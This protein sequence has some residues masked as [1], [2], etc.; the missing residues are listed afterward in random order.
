[1]IVVQAS[2]AAAVRSGQERAV[3]HAGGAARSSCRPTRWWGWGRAVG[4]LAGGPLGGLLLAAGS[5]ET[6]VI[7]DAVTFARGR[8]AHRARA[9]DTPTPGRQ[10]GSGRRQRPPRGSSRAAALARRPARRAAP[11]ARSPPPCWWLSSPTS[12]RASS[13][14]SSSCSWRGGCTADP[15][16]SACC[17]ACRPSAP[18]GAGCCWRCAGTGGAPC[19]LVAAAA[20]AF[21]LLDLTIWNGPAVTRSVAVYAALFALAGAPGVILETGGISFL[22]AAVSDRERG[23][24][25]AARGADRERRPGA[26]A[27]SRR[28]CSPRRWG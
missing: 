9:R 20:T 2:L 22:Q 21:G 4:R 8:A 7:A 17:V 12:R 26:R 1:M 16:R 10:R 19:S 28:G 6:I 27:S 24:V 13:W 18:S 15:P 3:A 14:S 23:R 5:L 11:P 25:F